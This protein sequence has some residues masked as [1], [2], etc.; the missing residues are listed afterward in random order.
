MKINSLQAQSIKCL[1]CCEKVE[2]SMVL[3]Q[4]MEILMKWA[5]DKGYMK[6]SKILGDFLVKSS[7]PYK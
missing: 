3:Q 5:V 1:K 7:I 6:D 2:F 4:K